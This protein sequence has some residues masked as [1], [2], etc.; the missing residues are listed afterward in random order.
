MKILLTVFCVLFILFAGGC[1]LTLVGLGGGGIGSLGLLPLGIA[2]L[3]VMLLVGLWG[4]NKPWLPA[5]YILGTADI[6]IAILGA[7]NALIFAASD[8]AGLE[9][10]IFLGVA[11]FA[12]KGGAT[13]YFARHLPKQT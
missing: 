4:A 10:P 6:L 8:T 12:L 2:A 11:F 7:F 3:N 13:L 5:F 9:V 1:A